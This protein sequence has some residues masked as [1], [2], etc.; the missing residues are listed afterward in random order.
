LSGD[1]PDISANPRT[2]AS[3]NFQS[4][5][6]K[7]GVSNLSERTSAGAA[8][9]A[10][11]RIPLI[12]CRFAEPIAAERPPGS[13]F[14]TSPEDSRI[15]H[16]NLRH[17]FRRQPAIPKRCAHDDLYRHDLQTRRR[18]PDSPRTMARNEHGKAIR[19]ASVRSGSECARRIDTGCKFGAANATPPGFTLNKNG[20]GQ[21]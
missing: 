8:S 19:G 15:G 18:Q 7:A 4:T 11:R 1:T 10:F 17:P 9:G 14:A 6:V 20:L 5:Y 12:A 13:V 2:G 21:F 16:R 3:R